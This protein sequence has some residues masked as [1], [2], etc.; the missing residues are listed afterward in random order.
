MGRVNLSTQA[1]ELSLELVRA[2][3][4]GALPESRVRVSPRLIAGRAAHS[5]APRTTRLSCAALL[6]GKLG[7]EDIE[8][9]GTELRAILQIRQRP[10]TEREREVMTL[11]MRGA[12][13]PE[14]G[15]R[16]GITRQCVSGHAT[17]ALA[18]M[19]AP[20]KFHA[21]Q[22]WTCLREAERTR[23]L[24]TYAEIELNGEQ[25]VSLRAPIPIRLDLE[26][27]MSA[28]ETHVAWLTCDGLSNREI[29]DIRGSSERTVANQVGSLFQKLGIARRTELAMLLL[30]L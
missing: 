26:S 25:L 10:F 9:R 7:V 11:L 28:A 15:R 23:G 17:N 3:E 22:V 18:K 2:G 6:A 5:P 24:A 13:E 29:A 16:F 20:S 30:G 8:R 27:K 4:A 21:L 19:G 14:I 12:S 1:A